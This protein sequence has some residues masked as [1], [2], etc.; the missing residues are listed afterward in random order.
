MRP[1]CAGGGVG[2][3][4][5]CNARHVTGRR[6]DENIEAVRA[7]RLTDW[8]TTLPCVARGPGATDGVNA[9]SILYNRQSKPSTMAASVPR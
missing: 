8:R 6:R 2:V 7:R 9:H 3:G 4:V 5:L 1:D